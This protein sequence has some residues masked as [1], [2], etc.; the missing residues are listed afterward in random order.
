[1]NETDVLVELARTE[2]RS[3]RRRRLVLMAAVLVVV[4]VGVG[5]YAYLYFLAEHRL[6][7]A[8]AEADRLDPGWHLSDI[9]ARRAVLADE[10][11]AAVQVLAAKA[12]QPTGWPSWDG[13]GPLNEPPAQAAKRQALSTSFSEIRPPVLLNDDQLKALRVELGRA[14]EAVKAARKLA[15]MPRGRYVVA[16]RPDYVSTLLP[17]AQQARDM[18][19]LLSFDVLLRAHDG[20][21]DGALVSCRAILNA[22]RSLGDEETLISQLVR[23]ACA[24]VALAKAERVLAQGQG[25]DAALARLQRA[26]A[27]EAEEPRLLYGLRG[28]RAGIDGFMELFQNGAISWS[29]M[30]AVVGQS[31]AIFG[32][33]PGL[34]DNVQLYVFAGSPRTNRAALLHYMTQ[35]VEAAKLPPEEQRQRF[36]QIVEESKGKMPV[37]ARVLLPACDKVVEA[38]LRSGAELR[39]GV[40]ALAAERYRMAHGHWPETAAALVPEFLPAVPLDLFDGKPLRLKRTERGVVVYTVGPDGEDN[41]GNLDGTTK[42]GTDR[43]VRLYDPARRRQ[44]PV[45]LKTDLPEDPWDDH[46]W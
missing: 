43:G 33:G 42:P 41:G 4:G 24:G 16:W 25:S 6:Q 46:V 1:M 36:K 29:Q 34:M 44:P 30:N 27:E 39:C 31:S 45:P 8:I 15:D 22:G 10:E 12:L 40:V 11:N 26:F 3:R 32:G 20:D 2:G 21:I 28:E 18:A 38:G 17:H 7:R 37:L 9:E 13:A 23:I 19:Y 14:A 5:W 35:C